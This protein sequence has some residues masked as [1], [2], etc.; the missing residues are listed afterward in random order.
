MIGTALQRV[1]PIAGLAA[2]GVV[3]YSV[4]TWWQTRKQE[5]A[6]P[7]TKVS[8]NLRGGGSD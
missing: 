7:E 6:T 3:T 1:T 4:V 2:V 5:A 8:F